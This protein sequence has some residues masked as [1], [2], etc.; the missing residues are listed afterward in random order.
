MT[1]GVQLNAAEIK[2]ALLIRKLYY[3]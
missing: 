3:G 1:T 2:T